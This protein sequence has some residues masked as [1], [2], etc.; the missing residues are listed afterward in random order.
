LL[1]AKASYGEF[2]TM[3]E[4]KIRVSIN[5]FLGAVCHRWSPLPVIDCVTDALFE[6][7]QVMRSNEPENV[8]TPTW[9]RV[10]DLD[11]PPRLF[12]KS[13]L[14]ARRDQ[15]LRSVDIWPEHGQSVMS[16]ISEFGPT[17]PKLLARLTDVM[18]LGLNILTF[19]LNFGRQNGFILYDI[20]QQR[21]VGLLTVAVTTYRHLMKENI[22]EFSA[23]LYDTIKPEE[24]FRSLFENQSDLNLVYYSIAKQKQGGTGS[25]NGR[26]SDDAGSLGSN[27]GLGSLSREMDI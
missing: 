1:I 18:M 19:L 17:P 14:D 8:A 16:H 10:L 5:F 13:V 2:H 4:D 24:R 6:L 23:A 22:M 25:V 27:V 12:M 3:M 11:R 7:D 9:S 15:S 21:L 26:D 20:Q